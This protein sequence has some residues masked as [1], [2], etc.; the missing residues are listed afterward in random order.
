M[1]RLR[2]P[3]L[4]DRFIFVT[5]NLLPYRTR[6]EEGDFERLA[7]SLARM[8]T[9]HGF[10]L[11]AWVFLPDHWHAIIHPPYPLTISTAL[12]S[13]KTSS[14]IGINVRRKEAGEEPQT[15]AGRPALPYRKFSLFWQAFGLCD[16][17][18]RT[19]TSHS[20]G[21]RDAPWSAAARRRLGMQVDL[22]WIGIQS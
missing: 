8:R 20:F 15:L 1:S 2:R 6:L 9:K 21:P 17:S 5:V 10:L 14:M 11:T 7:N 3:F 16:F 4:F 12:K 18:R 13:V 22:N 19:K